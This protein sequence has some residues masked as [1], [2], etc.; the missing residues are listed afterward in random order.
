MEEDD[1]QSCYEKFLDMYLAHLQ[2]KKLSA[3]CTPCRGNLMGNSIL[4]GRQRPISLKE[5]GVQNSRRSMNNCNFP[6]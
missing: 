1:M 2:K 5:A 6:F 4:D 3:S